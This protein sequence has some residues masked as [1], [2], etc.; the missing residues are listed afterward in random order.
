MSQFCQYNRNSHGLHSVDQIDQ[1]GVAPAALL[2]L[3]DLNG[4]Q[5]VE[6][7]GIFPWLIRWLL[8]AFTRFLSR[9]GC[10]AQNKIYFNFPQYRRTLF[11]FM[12]PSPIAHQLGQAVVQGRLSMN[13]CLWCRLGYSMEMWDWARRRR[14]RMKKGGGGRNMYVTEGKIKI[15]NK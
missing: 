13:V 3:H 14:D 12:C 5:R 6:M 1:R 7:K 15:K 11:Q 10:S 9:F 2:K 4:T 8:H